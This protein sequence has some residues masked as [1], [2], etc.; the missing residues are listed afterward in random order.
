M[1]ERPREPWKHRRALLALG[2]GAVDRLLRREVGTSVTSVDAAPLTA[3]SDDPYLRMFDN[4]VG[5]CRREPSI[6]ATAGEAL[7]NVK[8]VQTARAQGRYVED[9]V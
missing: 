8:V 5:A 4:F 1:L 2:L 9:L 3:T 6:G 7:L